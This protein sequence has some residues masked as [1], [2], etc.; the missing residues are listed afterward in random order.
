MKMRLLAI[1]SWLLVVVA[2]SASA[3]QSLHALASRQFLQS[4]LT[5]LGN[6]PAAALI[7]AR[8]ESGD[9]H[10]GD[11]IFVRVRGDSVLTDTFT[12]LFDLQLPLPAL[13][14]VPLRGVLR[15]ELK[16]TISAYL[17]RYLRDPIVE[18]RPLMRIVVE[19]Q[20]T[21]PGFVVAAPE[22]PLADVITAAGGFTQQANVTDIR[23]QRGATTILSGRKLTDAMGQGYSLDRLNLRAGDRVF[24]PGHGDSAKTL[25]IMSFVLSVP[26]AVLALTKAF[27]H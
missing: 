15:S 26:L 22:Q 27:S 2:G 7:R 8:L 17:S 24:V 20:V 9:F 5:R 14:A 6:D 19:G 3:Q 25:Q 13:G 4:E 23:L 18:V 11:R 10:A 1:G 12:V 21:K 16:D